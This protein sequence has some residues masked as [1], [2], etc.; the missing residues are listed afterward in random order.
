MGTV[1]NNTNFTVGEP[2]VT[3]TALTVPVSPASPL[4]TAY[5]TGGY[6]PA[7]NYW[8]ASNGSSLSNWVAMSGGIAQGLVPGPA[9]TWSSRAQRG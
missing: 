4:A 2:S 3:S 6:S 8:G 1:Y 7:N 5:W 9:P